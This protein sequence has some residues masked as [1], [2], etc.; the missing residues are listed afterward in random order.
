[1]KKLL[2]AL[3][4]GGSVC[5]FAQENFWT[6]LAE[7][8]FENRKDKDGYEVEVPLFSKHL[9]TFQGKKIKIKGYVIP[10]AEVGDQSRFMLSALPFN[11]CYFCGAA[12]PETVMEIDS[13]EKIKFT[14]KAIVMEGVL[15]L[16]DKDPNHHM[17]ILKSAHLTN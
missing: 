17:Y 4:L 10:L 16:N 6:T 7:V 1:M 11:L 14:S 5:A 2:L 9:K 3:L 13:S 15:I 12:G 8:G